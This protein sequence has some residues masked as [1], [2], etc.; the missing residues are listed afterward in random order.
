MKKREKIG[1]AVFI[2]MTLLAGMIGYG[3]D[4]LTGEAKGN[5]LGM[6]IWL[7]LPLLTGI[8]IRLINK[9]WKGFGVRP[10]LKKNLVWYLMALLAFPLLTMVVVVLGMICGVTTIGKVELEAVIS[11]FIGCFI[12]NFIKNIFE[13]FAWRGNL[14]PFLEKTKIKDG[15]LY[16]G[17]GLIWGCWHIPYYLFLLPDSYFVGTS[18][19]ATALSGLIVII[20]MTPLFIELYRIT[21]S[22]W[23]CVILHTMPN[24]IYSIFMMYPDMLFVSEKGEM[25][26]SPISGALMILLMLGAGIGL[27]AYRKGKE[28]NTID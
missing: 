16:V 14:V 20:A 27:R 9:E 10:R 12:G 4:N 17:C 24:V 11:V 22:V 3:V 7:T 18:R 23:P 2:S 28:I 6:G 25:F 5:S 21:K 13:E 26:F 1:L 8:V 15:G 19:V